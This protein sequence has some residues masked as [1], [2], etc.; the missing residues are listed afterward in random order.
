M[1]TITHL[2]T[3][4]DINP[5][6]PETRCFGSIFTSL[7]GLALLHGVLGRLDEAEAGLLCCLRCHC[8]GNAPGALSAVAMPGEDESW[9]S[10]RLLHHLQ[11]GS[12]CVGRVSVKIKVVGP[13]LPAD[14]QFFRIGYFDNGG[15]E[16]A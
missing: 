6:Q 8:H 13:E 11:R 14:R 5:K 4:T 2:H 1:S 15:S 3:Q 7:S 10:M 16:D 9:V 12:A